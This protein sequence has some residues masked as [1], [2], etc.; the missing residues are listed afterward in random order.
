MPDRAPVEV[1]NLDRYGSPPLPWSRP[2]DLLVANPAQP[3]TSYFLGTSRPDGRP[4]AAGI[5]ALLDDGDLYFTSG[6]GTRKARELAANP[7]CT[8]SVGLTGIDLVLEGE[9]ARVTDPWLPSAL[10]SFATRN[11]IDRPGPARRSGAGL[12][13]CRASRGRRRSLSEFRINQPILSVSEY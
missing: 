3:G 4:H 1:T 2:H 12:S 5:G 10:R 9:A 11:R 13:S 7:A 8:F 6:P